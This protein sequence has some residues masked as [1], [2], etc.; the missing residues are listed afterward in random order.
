MK[1]RPAVESLANY[2]SV[3][4]PTLNNVIYLFPLTVTPD[5]RVVDAI[6]LMSQARSSCYPLVNR[7]VPNQERA[8]CVLVIE[9]EQIV[10]IFTE[11]DV[12]RLTA[13]G[14]NL[15]A[16]AIAQ[17]MISPVMTLKQSQSDDI[18]TVL[19]ILHH[20]QI[21]HLPVVDDKNHVVGIITPE[22]IRQVLQPANLLRL[23]SVSEV[24]VKDNIYAPLTA[25]LFDI[26][27]LM[28]SQNISCVVIAE[29]DTRGHI[30]PQ[31]IITE[32]D[33]V[34]F[35]IL[36]L[37]F[38]QTQAQTVMSAPVFC[39]Y[40]QD[41]LWFAH[42]EMQRRRLRRLVVT[43]ETGEFM[44]IV[45]QTSFLQL[46]DPLE[47]ASVITALQQQVVRQGTELKQTNQQLQQ[48]E[49]KLHQAYIDLEKKVAQ[50]TAELSQANARLQQEIQERQQ[51][52]LALRKSEAK[53]WQQ[54]AEIESIY[55][56]VPIGLSFM[57]TNMKF[58]RINEYLAKINNLPVSEHIGQTLWDVLPNLS[59]KL[60]PLYQQVIQSGLPVINRKV[61]G[62]T[63]AQPGVER[64][65]LVNY[66][67]L[68]GHDGEILGINSVVQDVT[69]SQRQEE[70]LRHQAQIINQIHESVIATDLQGYITSWNP[71]AE[72]LTGYSASEAIA[73]HISLLYPGELAAVLEHQ[74]IAPLLEKGEHEIELT[75]QNKFGKRFDVLLSLSLLRSPDQTPIGMI[76]YSMD[77]TKRK[78]AEVALRESQQ[79]LEEI[80][81]NSTAVIFLKDIQGRY[82]LVNRGF[83][84]LFHLTKAQIQGKTDY[85]L[86][87]QTAAESLLASDR[88]VIETG[89]SVTV[90]ELIPIGDSTY[91]YVTV[92]FPLVDAEGAP[93]AVCGI[94]T[95]ITKHR[96]AEEKIRE[97]AALIDI[98]TDAIVVCNLDQQILFWNQSAER[99][100][101]WT[102]TE[103][104]GKNA[105][106]LLYTKTSPQREVARVTVLKDGSWEGELHQVTKNGK[107]IIVHSRWTL[108]QDELGNPKSILIVNTD[109]TEKKQ[110]EA[111][112]LRTQ[113][114]ENLGILASGI[115]HDLNNIL[116]PILTGAQLLPLRLVNLD[117]QSRQLLKMQQD[118][119]KRGAELI[120]QILSFA[121]GVEGKRFPLQVT[122]LL[123]EIE[124]IVKSTFPKS[125]EIQT[126]IPSQT[127]ATVFA[128]PTQIHQVLMNLCI[129]ARDAM[130]NG[131]TLRLESENFWVDENYAQMNL[132]AK[133][134]LYVVITVSDTGCG[135]PPEILHRIFDPFFTTKESGKGTGLGLSTVIGILNNHGGFINVES[136]ASLG[137]QFKVYLPAC[138][139]IVA[140][141]TDESEIIKGNG[142]L[143][144][145][146][147]DEASIRDIN[148][149]SLENYN[150][151]IITANDGIEAV[152]SYA[153][154]QNQISLVLMD[155]EMPSM[156]GILA[157]QVLCKMNPSMKI[158][159]VSGLE[160][161]RDRL[162][163]IGLLYMPAFLSKPY[164]I[165]DLLE[166]V[167]LI[168]NN[169]K[170]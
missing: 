162:Q 136:Q 42:Q 57:D 159:A 116:T 68:I 75:M 103:V 168:L 70:M 131:G 99:I 100:Y 157:M 123:K 1:L 6:A 64:D 165:K 8:S 135:I 47:M 59:D 80:I 160:S 167:N 16:V 88:Q 134:G 141:K 151:Q 40:P 120:K 79:H 106:E 17:V 37:D 115:A 108:V 27:K 154:Y 31:G 45:T 125:I 122:H 93:Y 3:E 105:N 58:V 36:G 30:I 126:Y 52:E 109:I 147:D 7:D 82:I 61:R 21:R 18:L 20:H 170:K 140:E 49:S 33:I 91:N 102:A 13:T 28:N 29:P 60:E 9:K 44:G 132:N 81:N 39:V 110:L 76:G 121:R 149:A 35:Q 89:T 145:I 25:K 2:V 114:L 113:R 73:Q 23:R 84:E 71:G 118:S 166:T 130:P 146:V 87:P 85:E 51:T 4:L 101:G 143:I 156:D 11:W 10:G 22:A 92:K 41:S 26:A 148:K 137:S 86:F 133:V 83:T 34:Q 38:T 98:A 117:E 161:N 111:Q 127:T 104:L 144:L 138:D 48:A 77:I 32:R 24:T 14:V 50:R 96:Q 15:S 12:V 129:N 66:Y 69:D 142:E 155:I 97:Q 43:S 169:S 139:Q 53:A 65:W 94:S 95:D 55:A 107:N 74:V 163:D 90:E 54:L 152:S 119:A 164:T 56:S 153:Q 78:Q 63:P 62:T 124:Q 158:I 112:F 46:F 150:Y 19:S 5:T 72:R 128:D 67:P